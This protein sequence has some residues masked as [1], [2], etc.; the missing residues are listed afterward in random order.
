MPDLIQ[1]ERADAIS[2]QFAQLSES[3]CGVYHR[4]LGSNAIVRV[5]GKPEASKWTE[6]GLVG[7]MLLNT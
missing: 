7:Q 3:A 6:N 1:N 2:D 5:T 4:L